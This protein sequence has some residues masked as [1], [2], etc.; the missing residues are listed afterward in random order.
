MNGPTPQRPDAAASFP[1]LPRPEDILD[2]IDWPALAG[3]FHP[4]AASIPEDL[5]RLVAPD[6]AVRAAALHVLGVASVL[7][8]FYEATVPAMVY[9]AANLSHPHLEEPGPPG[10]R[11]PGEPSSWPTRVVLLEWL[12]GLAYEVRDHL[13]AR[14]GADLGPEMRAFLD[15]RPGFYAAQ[16]PFFDHPD[17]EVRHAAIVAAVPLVEHPDLVRHRDALTFRARR[18]LADRT[19]HR[20]HRDRIFDALRAWGHD[21]ADLATPDDLAAFERHAHYAKKRSTP[22]G[23]TEHPPF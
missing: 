21:T 17:V 23:Y 13:A 18:L 22:G 19:S 9:V 20:Y 10:G 4:S 2:G 11:Q 3:E 7:N 15:L 1:P 8:S 12:G 14:S 5:R 16:R 6:P